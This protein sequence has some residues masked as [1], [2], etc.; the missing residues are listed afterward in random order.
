V[1]INQLAPRLKRQESEEG[2]GDYWAD[3]KTRQVHLSDAGHEHAEELITE[4]GLLQPGESLYDAANIRL[5]HHL[6]AALARTH[7]SRRQHLVRN[8]EVIIV[9]GSPA[10]PCGPALVSLAPNRRGEE[11]V[12]VRERGRLDPFQTTSACTRSCRA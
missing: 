4:A 6:N 8:G 10:A 11:G 5:M 1:R 12:R 9:D 3:E 2:E 7:L